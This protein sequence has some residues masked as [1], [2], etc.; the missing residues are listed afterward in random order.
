M[1]SRPNKRTAY[2]QYAC[3]YAFLCTDCKVCDSRD[4]SALHYCYVWKHCKSKVYL[5][6]HTAVASIALPQAAKRQDC[7][8]KHSVCGQLTLHVIHD[9]TACLLVVTLTQLC[10]LC[11]L[12]LSRHNTST[13]APAVIREIIFVERK[14]VHRTN[15]R[16]QHATV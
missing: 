15:I 14:S 12:P 13:K 4:Q 2:Q 3:R 9:M 5:I 7:N 8:A 1:I 6:Y 16:Q 10:T 11:P